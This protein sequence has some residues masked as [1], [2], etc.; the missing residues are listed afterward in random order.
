MAGQLLGIMLGEGAIPERWLVVRE[1]WVEIGVLAV[2]FGIGWRGSGE[3]RER[4]PPW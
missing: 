4:Y 1:L 2:V 3:W